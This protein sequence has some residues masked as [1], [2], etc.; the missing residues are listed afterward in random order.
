M[1][2]DMFCHILPKKYLDRVQKIAP[3]AKDMNKRVRSLF[4]LFNLDDRFKLMDKFEDYVQVLTLAAPPI[5]TF[6]PPSIAA[7][8]ATIA[9]DSLREMVDKYPDRFIGFVA[10]LPLN[11]VDASLREAE[12]AINSLGALGIQLF[13]NVLG[14]PLDKPE[15]EPLFQYMA[16]IDRPIWLH[17]TRGADFP[18]YKAER[19]SHYEIWFIFGWPYETSCCMAHLVFARIFEKYPNIKII[20][21]HLGGIAPYQAGRVGHA[22]DMLGSRTSDEDY[23]SLMKSMKRRPID[24]FKMFY[25]DTALF[26]AR[27]STRC[28]IQFF[29]VDHVVFGTDMPFDCRPNVHEEDSPYIRDTIDIIE[30]MDILTEHEKRAIFEGNA[31]KLLKI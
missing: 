28:G 16:H 18:D 14:K 15:F 3:D 6:G 2:I 20:T 26:G 21:H 31:K 25:A 29:G 1:K 30:K 7:E 24:Y 22:W 27:E 13:T 17:P 19:K 5:E 4:A 8:L 10:S 12:R 9:N 11:D 23:T